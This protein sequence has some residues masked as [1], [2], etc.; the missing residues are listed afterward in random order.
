M[1][2]LNALDRSNLSQARLGTLE[3]DLGM[4]G[5]DFNVVTSILFVGYLLMQIPSNIFL[6][7]VKPSIY[8][9]TCMAIWGVISAAQG[10]VKNYGGLLAC[11]FILGFMEVWM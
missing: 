10:A 6:V 5:N 8:L 9:S 3:T 4:V 11:R 1:Y 7:R 2:L